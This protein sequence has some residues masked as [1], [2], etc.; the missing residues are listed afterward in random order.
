[1]IEW[2]ITSSILIAVIIALRFILKGKISLRLQYALWV[3]VLLRLLVPVSFCSTEISVMNAVGQSA[4]E[5]SA[6]TSTVV[7]YIGGETPDLAISE[8]DPALSAEEQEAQYELNRQEWQAEMDASKAETGTPVT[9]LGI[10]TIVWG[11]GSATVGLWLIISNLRFAASVR[12]TRRALVV[13]DGK[14]PVYVTEAVETPCLFGLFRPA[15]YLTPEASVDDT[16]L[17]HTIEHEMT[18]FRHRDHIWS[19][20]RGVCLALHW[21][22]PLVWWAA[23]LSRND[24]ELACDEATIKRIGENE[25]AEYGRTLIRMTCQKRPALLLTA[26]TMTGSKNS[27][28]E[29]IMLIAKKPKTAIY[30]LVAVLLIAAVAVGCTFTGATDDN[31]TFTPDTVAMVQPLSSAFPPDAITDADTVEYLWNLYQSFNFDGTAETIG[32]ENV[33]SI[34][35]AFSNSATDESESFTIHQGGLCVLGEDY[36]TYYILVDGANIYNDFLRCFEEAKDAESTSEGDVIISVECGNTIPEA[37]VDYATDYTET[38]LSYYTD[39]LGYEIT[40]AKIVGLTQINTG[41]A[42]LNNGVSMY[43]LEYRFLPADPDEVMLVGGM[44]MEDDYITE[45]GSTGQP[46]LLLRWDDSGDTTSWERICVTNTDVIEQD[47]GT[48]EMLA[49]YGDAY[50][51]AA[52]ELYEKYKEGENGEDENGGTPSPADVVSSLFDSGGSV[53]LTLHL[54]NDGAYNT[55]SA[56]DWYA[57]RFEVLLNGYEWTELE[58]PSTEPSDFWLTAISLDGE[59]NM[60]FWSDGDAGTVQYSDGSGAIY[61]WSASPLDDF[62]VSIAEDIRAEYDNL[63]VDYSRISFSLSGSAE[64]AA[65]YFVHSAYGSHMTNLAPGNMYGVSDYE[66]VNWEV[67][68]V[69]GDGDAVVGWFECAVIP[70]DMDSPGIWAGNTGEGTGEYEGWLTYYREF[71]LQKQEDGY[72]HCIGLGTGGYTLPE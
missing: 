3:L 60:T 66:V 33:W 4:S 5:S 63:D 57:G 43:L 34:A 21:Y 39:E 19:L 12:K 54:A 59:Q 68:E 50:T 48:P 55:Y 24:S 58:M 71:V 14:L 37:V 8:P 65:D 38:Q 45:W 25:R 36:E 49:E 27:I 7:G 31:A 47:Y 72:W 69:S 46:Y 11:I 56:S 29:R 67:R 52:M 9:V 23:V 30:T 53:E 1:M 2:I 51:A 42:G 15:I 6:I 20:L 17:R 64:D 26:T 32:K 16:V 18:H 61:Y 70:W 22:N 40:E 44:K 41:T 10:L 13:D 62:S 28:K 35:V